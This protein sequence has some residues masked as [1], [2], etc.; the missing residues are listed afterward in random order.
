MCVE[1]SRSL[2]PAQRAKVI[3]GR[4]KAYEAVHP[5]TKHGGAA[6]KADGGKTK[7]AKLASFAANTAR[8]TGKPERSIQSDAIRAKALGRDLDRIAGTSLDKGAAQTK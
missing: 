2:T 1:T 5:E 7:G 3:A 4:K 8:R 6:G